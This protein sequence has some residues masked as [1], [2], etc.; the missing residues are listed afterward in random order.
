MGLLGRV[1]TGVRSN[2]AS[3]ESRANGNGEEQ[4]LGERQ[5]FWDIF[6]SQLSFKEERGPSQRVGRTWI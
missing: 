6:A 5:S 1:E 3:R 2:D 4:G